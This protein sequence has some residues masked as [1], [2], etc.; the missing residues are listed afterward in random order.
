MNTDYESMKELMRLLDKYDIN[1]SFGNYYS[2]D[3]SETIVGHWLKIDA[4]LDTDE[5]D[6]TDEEYNN[7]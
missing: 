6:N 5:I 3:G 2:P 1:Y 4:D 7:N